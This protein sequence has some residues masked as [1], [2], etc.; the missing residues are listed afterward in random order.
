M[1]V[2]DRSTLAQAPFALRLRKLFRFARIYGIRRALFKAAGRLRMP[3]LHWIV[4]RSSAGKPDIGIIG[5]GQFA[6]ATI[7]Y[8]LL[9]RRGRCI[10]QCFDIDS[11]AAH[12]FASGLAVKRVA[13]DATSLITDPDLRV[14]YV[15]SNHSSHADYALAALAAGKIVYIEKP[16]A[17]SR[18]QLARLMAV[19]MDDQSSIFAGY[20]RPFSQAILRLRRECN[21]CHGPIT[22]NCFVTGHRIPADHWYRDVGEGT[23]ICGNVGHWLDLAVHLLCW[24]QLPDRWHISVTWS[25]PDARD[26][27]LAIALTS[28]RGD[29]V[30][31]VLASRSEP[32][33]GINETINLQW[34]DV[35]AKIDDFRAMAVWKG[36]GL[37][38]YRFWPKDVG[39]VVSVM[40]PFG[41]H[42]R[43]WCEVELSTMLMLR[44]ADMVSGNQRQADISFSRERNAIIGDAIRLRGSEVNHLCGARVS[45]KKG[46][47]V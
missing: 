45:L 8:V 26:D 7:G 9:T 14:V 20:N 33:E 19:T 21:E 41:E 6:F 2:Q 3:R 15:A 27:D 11:G 29:L 42:R 40:Q 10:R 22:L 4:W 13:L 31:I 30:N 34:G 32:F 18:E 43:A 46:I 28:D 35:I 5:C 47:G 24:G 36:S 38:R 16:I 25:D 12:S 1:S 23:R 17:V 39:H 44:I 37:K